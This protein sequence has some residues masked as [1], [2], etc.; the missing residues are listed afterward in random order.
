[1]KNGEKIMKGVSGQQR[2]PTEYFYNTLIPIP[3]FQEQLRIVK[4]LEKL[5]HLSDILEESI[6]QS[7]SFNEN[8]LKQVLR[9]ALQNH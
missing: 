4:K 8:L 6:K 1:L 3:P 7:T 9:E 2:V 5:M